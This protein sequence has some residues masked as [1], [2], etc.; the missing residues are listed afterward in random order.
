MTTITSVQ[1]GQWSAAATWDT[2]TV[3]TN[4]DDVYINHTV[5]ISGNV[6]AL[7]CNIVAGS[8]ITDSTAVLTIDIP[9]WTMTRLTVDTR[10]IKMNGIRLIQ[11]VTARHIIPCISSVG[12]ADAYGN[13]QTL[14]LPFYDASNANFGM[15]DDT[16]PS[17]TANLDDQVNRGSGSNKASWRSAGVRFINATV[18]W[19]KNYAAIAYDAQLDVMTRSPYT[20]LLVTPSVIFKGHIQSV[21]YTD[22]AGEACYGATIQVV[23]G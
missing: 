5:T 1:N 12:A 14:T 21:Q 3:P 15:S 9:V 13:G 18:K 19:P 4:A 7:S 22:R 11:T 17:L 10:T 23:E 6:A 8:L 16:K 2:G 20:V